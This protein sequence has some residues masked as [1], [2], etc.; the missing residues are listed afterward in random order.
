MGIDATELDNA[1]DKVTGVRRDT[2]LYNF[3]IQESYEI[4]VEIP[5]GRQRR[6][7]KA[8]SPPTLSAQIE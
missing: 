8:A 5:A 4:S 3:A 2:D 1:K 7:K 6:E